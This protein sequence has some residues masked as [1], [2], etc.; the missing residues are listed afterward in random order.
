MWWILLLFAKILLSSVKCLTLCPSPFELQ[1]THTVNEIT[2]MSSVR[3]SEAHPFRK[4]L[5]SQ[6]LVCHDWNL[7]HSSVVFQAERIPIVWGRTSLEQR[8]SIYSGRCSE[9][10]KETLMFRLWF[11]TISDS[12]AL[13]CFLYSTGLS[14]RDEA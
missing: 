14:S 8:N 10:E 13:L 6:H 9:H 12:I 7:C 1:N 2:C 4:G 5:L 3:R 11:I